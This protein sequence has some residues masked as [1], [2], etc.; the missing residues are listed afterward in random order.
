MI[1]DC[2]EITLSRGSAV[3]LSDF[4]IAFFAVA[5]DCHVACCCR[6]SGRRR[7]LLG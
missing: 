6:Q 2:D 4:Q 3:Q 7:F 1:I 5:V